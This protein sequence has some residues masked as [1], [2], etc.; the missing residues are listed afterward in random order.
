MLNCFFKLKCTQLT[1]LFV[2]FFFF[3][4]V[5]QKFLQWNTCGWVREY[6]RWELHHCLVLPHCVHLCYWRD[7]WRPAGEPAG[8][9]IRK[10]G[11]RGGSFRSAF[12]RVVRS[13]WPCLC[14]GKGLWWELLCWC[15]L[16]ALWWASAGPAGCLPWSSLDASSRGCTQVGSSRSRRN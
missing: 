3:P 9:Q 15:L 12:E 10:V 13:R 6:S 5:H 11:M 14:A 7:G 4:P 16:G 2:I 1:S 8:D